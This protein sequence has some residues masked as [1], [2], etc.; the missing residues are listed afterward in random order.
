MMNVI[1]SCN[2]FRGAMMRATWTKARLWGLVPSSGGDIMGTV[3][4]SVCTM[5]SAVLGLAQL[6][7]GW[8]G[9]RF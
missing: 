3:R 7:C 5:D 6:G 4:H 9:V 1:P 8:Y 2:P